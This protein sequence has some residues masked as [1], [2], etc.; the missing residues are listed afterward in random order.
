MPIEN[1][2]A[3]SPRIMSTMPASSSDIRS[4]M[5]SVSRAASDRL[6]GAILLGHLPIALILAAIYGGWT[7][8]IVVGAPLALGSF[9]L[10]RVAAGATSTRISVGLAYMCFSA[11]FIHLAHGLVEMHFHIFS[12]LALLLVYRDWRVPT[13]AAAAIAIH[14]VAFHVMQTMGVGVYVMDHAM[15]GLAGYVMVGVHAAFVVFE[16]GL[17]ITMSVQL[18]Q[19]AMRTQMVFETLE[20]LGAGRTDYLPEGDG[21]AAAM[22]SVVEAVRALDEFAMELNRSV[23]E[24]REAHFVGAEKLVGAFGSVATHMKESSTTLVELR[25]RNAV[26]HENTRRFLVEELGQTILAMRDGDLTR[27]VNTGFGGDYDAT[28]AAFNSAIEAIRE[29]LGDL[30]S[31]SEQ[32]E[33]ASGE[34]ASGADSLAQL[35]SEQAAGLEEITASLHE[36]A[37]LGQSNASDVES[38]RTATAGA[39]GAANSGVASVQRLITSMDETRNSARETAKIVKT[40]D[41]IAFQT[42]LLALNASVEAARAGDAGRGFA[43]VADEVRALALRCAEAARTTSSLIEDT[44]TRVEGGV[45]ISHDVDEQLRDVSKRITTVNGVMER[46]GES[47]VSQQ[48][49][50]K[51]I[52]QAVES[53]NGAVQNAAANA[54]ESA[55]AAQELSAQ[56][57]AQR[58]QTE[59]F[60]LESSAPTTRRGEATSAQSAKRPARRRAPKAEFAEV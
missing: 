3:A 13:V 58:T 57:R 8:A 39:E 30:Q 36:L 28:G 16:T 10:T 48:S 60:Q 6:N 56:A 54:E 41:E 59:R 49:G 45:V 25:T 9:L 24:R 18:E 50:I 43:V 35:T 47:T 5:L 53:L 27:T 26:G 11:L 23:S 14:H 40:I 37:A 52:R 19:E 51:E 46:I 33:G 38:A 31:S 2:S 17:L 20:N 22:R 15:P 4:T 42:N 34:I 55:A 12:A 7:T 1:Q 32:M 44:V 21:I 29:A